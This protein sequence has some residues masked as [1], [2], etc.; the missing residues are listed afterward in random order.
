MPYHEYPPAEDVRQGYLTIAYR[1]LFSSILA[2]LYIDKSKFVAS[3]NYAD[4]RIRGILPEE[5]RVCEDT[6]ASFLKQ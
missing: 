6:L 4:G 5:A 1:Q 3:N 2:Q